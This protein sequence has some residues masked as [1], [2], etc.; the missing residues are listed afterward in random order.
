MYTVWQLN[1]KT[2]FISISY[3]SYVSK[4]ILIHSIQQ[5]LLSV[6]G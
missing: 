3:E 1:A 4:F 6:D 5:I 2:V